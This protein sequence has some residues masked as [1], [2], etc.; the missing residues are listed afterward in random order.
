MYTR[1]EIKTLDYDGGSIVGDSFA[2]GS[3]FSNS[4]KIVFPL[5]LEGIN[6]LDEVKIEVGIKTKNESSIPNLE[7]PAFVNQ[8]RVGKAQ[9]MSYIDAIYEFVPLGTFYVKSVDPDRNENKT[10]LEAMDGFIFMGGLYESKLNYPAK[11][12]DVALEIANLSGLSVN[13]SDFSRLSDSLIDKM[14]GYTCRQA[15]GLIAQFEA[16]YVNFDRSGLL[17]V[18]TLFDPNYKVNTSEYYSKGLKKN[19]LLYRLGGISCK[20][21]NEENSVLTAGSPT[22]SQISLEN[23]VMTQSLLN[24]IYE[25]LENLSFYP[26]TLSWRGNPAIEVGDWV[27]LADTKG[28]LFKMPILTYKM[29]FSGGLKATISA[30]AKSSPQTV[31]QYRGQL[32]QTIEWMKDRISAAGKNNI[33]SGLDAPLYP[34]EHDIWFR[35]KGPDIELCTWEKVGN[36]IFDWVVQASTVPNEDLLEAIANAAQKGSDAQKAA[37]KAKELAESAVEGYIHVTDKTIFDHAVIKEAYIVDGSITSAKIGELAVNTAN[38]ANAAITNAKIGEISANKITSGKIDAANVNIINLN[39]DSISSGTI[40]SIKIKGGTIEGTKI[41]GTEIIGSR[42]TSSSKDFQMIMDVGSFKW[43]NNNNKSDA[44]EIKVEPSL[45][46]IGQ[47]NMKLFNIGEF[48][49][50]NGLTDRKYLVISRVSD[51][52]N[53]DVKYLSVKNSFNFNANDTM[54]FYLSS[55]STKVSMVKNDVKHLFD[56]NYYG[57][58]YDF[59]KADSLSEVNFNEG[60]LY[61]KYKTNKLSEYI[62]SVGTTWGISYS[63]KGKNLFN[64][65]EDSAT[66]ASTNFYLTGKSVTV[67]GNFH[68]RGSKN[69]IHLTR[70]GVRATPAY[71]LAESYLGDI[72]RNVTDE[73]CQKWVPIDILFSDTVNLDIPYEVFLQSYEKSVVWVSDFKSDAFLV[74]SDEPYTRFG[75]EIKAKRIGYENERLKMQDYDNEKIE[76]IWR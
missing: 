76:K 17:T 59:T 16:G 9:L 46:N 22:G 13:E 73:H 43:F 67:N 10:T 38:I 33:H 51:T 20:I 30:N 31:T 26:G 68:V 44:F 36:T 75:W 35:P 63:S 2:I 19:E 69:A 48:A 34:K 50:S 55:S 74:C 3:T 72:G 40:S 12:R 57:L 61:L 15:I 49:M 71:E 25:K 42:I 29:S 4:V 52:L 11:I 45:N 23:K 28:T 39:A 58:S 60:G 64:L 47:A 7:E 18:R 14:E 65:Y 53:L 41:I 6:E 27:T 5:I 24:I 1:K 21:G 32:Q 62:F 37:D 56:F 70:D 54:E 8:A 66:I